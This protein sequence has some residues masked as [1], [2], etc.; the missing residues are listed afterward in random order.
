MVGLC[1]I[2]EAIRG[3]CGAGSMKDGA[4]MVDRDARVVC[5]EEFM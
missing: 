1:D 2:T 3:M 5:G 4:P